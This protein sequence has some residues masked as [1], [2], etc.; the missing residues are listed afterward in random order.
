MVGVF[1]D[2]TERKRLEERLRRLNETLEERVRQRTAEL[3]RVHEQLRQSQ[4]LEA[5]GQLTG[6]VAH[7]FNNLLT[8][9]IGSLDMLQRR[10]AA[11]ERDQRLIGGALESAERAKTLVQR[12]LAFARRQPLQPGAVDISALVGGMADL[13]GSTSGPQIKLSIDIPP[14][15]P[16]A[17]SDPNQLEMALLNLSVNARDAMPDGGKLTISGS[18]EQVG[19]GHRT[20]LAPGQYLRLSVSDTGVGMDEVTLA[21]AVEPFFSTKGVGKGTGLGLSMVHGLASQLGGGLLISSRQSLGTTVD[22]FL[23]AAAAEE[24]LRTATQPVDGRSAAAAGRVLLVDDEEL[25]RAS[26]AEMLHDLG[27]AVVETASAKEALVELA[28][29]RFDYVVTDHLMPGLSG[30]ELARQI[31]A[32]YPRTPVLVISGYS[33]L[34]GVALDIPRLTKPFRQDELAR[35]IAGLA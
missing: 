23:P 14:G 16:C 11:S 32:E 21:K 30:T 33:E 12:L 9:I 3:E 10:A 15:L 35:S 5:M 24:G 6:G 25:V 8:P 18:V 1:G 19:E 22:L 27:Y 4:K 20:A 29:E 31:A 26:T 2:V 17:R 34:E 28:R 13:I 7:D